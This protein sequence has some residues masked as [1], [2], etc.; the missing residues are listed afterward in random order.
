L[1]RNEKSAICEA[2]FEF[3][4]ASHDVGA[5]EI[6][7][8]FLENTEA[9]SYAMLGLAIVVHVGIDALVEVGGHAKC[10]LDI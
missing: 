1:I 6:L 9:L 4:G 3:T 10:E 2:I 8:A 7:I 5:P